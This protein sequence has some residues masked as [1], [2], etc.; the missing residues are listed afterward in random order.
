MAIESWYLIIGLLLLLIVIIG[1]RLTRLPCTTAM[2]YLA[3]GAGLQSFGWL[4]LDFARHAHWLEMASEIAVIISLFSVGLKLRLP[5]GDRRW[6]VPMLMATLSMVITVALIAVAGVVVFGL[7]PGAAMILGAVLA[8]TDPVL[9]SDVQIEHSGD[10][11]PVRLAL[12]GEAGLNDGTAFPFLLLGLALL[13][14]HDPAIDGIG[15]LIRDWLTM[16]VL[17]KIGA[18]FVVGAGVGRV[19]SK[20]VLYQRQSLREA[21][22][23]DDFLALGLIASAYGLAH[24]IDANGFIAVFAAGWALRGIE[25]RASETAVAADAPALAA[26]GEDDRAAHPRLAPVHM[27]EAVVQFNS[28]IER[29]AELTLVLLVGALVAGHGLEPMACGFALLLIFVIRP[30][31]VAPVCLAAGWRRLQVGLVAWFGVRGIGSIYYL[32]YAVTHGLPSA[33]VEPFT[34]LTLTVVTASILLHGVSCTPV[35]QIYGAHARRL[36]RSG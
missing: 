29:I 18:G 10:R 14:P 2:I 35:M 28:Q 9:A 25:R 11:D 13:S 30:L 20:L 17:W 22:G 16:D 19:V 21:L 5:L 36:F 33:Y 1:R 27:T 8:P 7:E 15:T 26:M 3:I 31:A 32:A 6:R 24:V 34:S 4:S 23:L 12:T